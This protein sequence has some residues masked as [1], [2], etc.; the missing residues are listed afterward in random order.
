MFA[1][2]SPI[3]TAAGPLIFNLA[4]GHA[5]D[6]YG[7]QIDGGTIMCTGQNCFKNSFIAFGVCSGSALLVALVLLVKKSKN[8]K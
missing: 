2:A 6:H 7:T 5:Y 8:N 4:S 1:L 3:A